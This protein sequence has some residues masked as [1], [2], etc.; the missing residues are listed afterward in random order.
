MLFQQIYF[1]ISGMSV[2]LIRE[3]IFSET[4]FFDSKRVLSRMKSSRLDSLRKLG[5]R[6]GPVR[7]PN[8][9]SRSYGHNYEICTNMT[10]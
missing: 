1:H 9:S 8:N 5:P 3:L 4:D 10:S 7:S 2:L 6:H